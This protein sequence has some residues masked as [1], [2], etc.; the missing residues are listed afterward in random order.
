MSQ[1]SQLSNDEVISRVLQKIKEKDEVIREQMVQLEDKE[2]QL[3]QRDELIQELQERISQLEKSGSER[4]E[5]IAK[6]N[7]LLD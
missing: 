5:L 1:V 6:L 4:E 7:D 2:V 3:K